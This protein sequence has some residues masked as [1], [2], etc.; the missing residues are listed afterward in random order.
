MI[1]ESIF[2]VLEDLGYDLTHSSTSMRGAT[3]EIDLHG[4]AKLGILSCIDTG[5]I[6]NKFEV[7]GVQVT[8]VSINI[9]RDFE[10]QRILGQ[11]KPIH[12][13]Y[14]EVVEIEI[15]AVIDGVV[16]SVKVEAKVDPNS[17]FEIAG[18]L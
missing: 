7:I 14:P 4:T 15:S 9:Q 11:L 2:K 3:D 6:I 8:S 18:A 5:V 16:P 1:T 12:V 17:K 10:T 13:S